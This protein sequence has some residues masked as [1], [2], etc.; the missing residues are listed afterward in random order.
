MEWVV[1]AIQCVLELTITV[2]TL[3]AEYHEA[4]TTQA[5]RRA[6]VQPDDW[7]CPDTA[8]FARVLRRQN[9]AT[10]VPAEDLSSL[11]LKRKHP[12][13]DRDLDA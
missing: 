11:S 5:A 13:W 10:D 4:S 1:P 2:G 9:E 7:K 3:I 12:L 8:E 6:A